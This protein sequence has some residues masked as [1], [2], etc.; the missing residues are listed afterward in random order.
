VRPR[1]KKR[2]TEIKTQAE[3]ESELTKA[4][5][6]VKGDY[7][8]HR[9]D[10]ST[11]EIVN[12]MRDTIERTWDEIFPDDPRWQRYDKSASAD[13][14]A[15]IVVRAMLY[16]IPDGRLSDGAQIRDHSYEIPLCPD[17]RQP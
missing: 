15:R 1:K 5:K 4:V 3:L 12:V 10:V 17:H 8:T 14:T 7:S 16:G 6:V 13:E 9:N 11:K 2:K